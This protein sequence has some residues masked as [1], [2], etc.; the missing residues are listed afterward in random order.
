MCHETF[1]TEV[2]HSLKRYKKLSAYV[3]TKSFIHRCKECHVHRDSVR[4][5]RFGRFLIG[6]LSGEKKILFLRGEYFSP[7][8]RSEK[9]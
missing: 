8:M 9:S 5:D 6:N 1:Q 7:G 3:F 2:Q 4:T